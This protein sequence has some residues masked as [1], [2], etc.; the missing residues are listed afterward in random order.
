MHR[1]NA[2]FLLPMIE[3]IPYPDREDFMTNAGKLWYEKNTQGMLPSLS[4]YDIR[5]VERFAL[6]SCT[7]S[8]VSI[9]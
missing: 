7:L 8:R 6:Y 9:P 4:I 1:T 2:S 3:A 5:T